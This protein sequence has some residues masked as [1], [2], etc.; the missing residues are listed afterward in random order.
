MSENNPGVPDGQVP[1]PPSGQP[2]FESPAAAPAPGFPPAPLGQPA[3][4]AQ[5]AAP[6]GQPQDPYTPQ[7]AQPAAPYGQPQD[8]YGQP[9]AYGQQPG[10]AQPQD[11]YAQQGYAQPA[12]GQP[13]YGQPGFGAPAKKMNTLALVGMIIA[14]L[15]ILVCWIPFVGIAGVIGG[16]AGVVLGAL[17][18]RKIRTDLQVGGKGL[19][20]TSLIVGVLAI[21]G[22][23]ASTALAV[24]AIN[25]I[26]DAYTDF[27]ASWDEALEDSESWSEDLESTLEDGSEVTEE[28]VAEAVHVGVGEATTVGDYTVTVTAVNPNANDLIAAESE[29]NQAPVHQYML[30]DLTVVYEGDLQ[31][32]PWIELP[33]AFVGNDAVSYDSTSC[34]ADLPVD[35][36]DIDALN[37]GGSGSYQVC[38]DVPAEAVAGGSVGVGSLYDLESVT[39]FWDQ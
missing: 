12:Y 1:P 9:P 23:I 17:G 21:L 6:Y 39:A 11:T 31:G 36:W 22:G 24:V 18:L 5:P 29:Y 2:T 26:D 38:M 10:Y 34:F 35:G 15:S 32:N 27:D 20:L 3:P 28:E 33:V 4:D 13:A 25:S 14:I 7:G 19:A 30:V 16:I 8:A 37:P